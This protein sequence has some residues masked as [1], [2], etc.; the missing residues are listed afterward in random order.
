MMARNYFKLANFK[1][2]TKVPFV[3]SGLL[4]GWLIINDGISI[5]V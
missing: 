4:N 5:G 3:G 1:L 2:G